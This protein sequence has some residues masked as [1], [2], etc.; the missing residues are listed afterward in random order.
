MIAEGPISDALFVTTTASTSARGLRPA[1]ASQNTSPARS[2]RP[3]FAR[4][5]RSLPPPGKAVAPV[6]RGWR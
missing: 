1:S 2:V 6:S 4:T 3:R 5:G